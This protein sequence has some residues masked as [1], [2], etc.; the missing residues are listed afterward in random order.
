M[1]TSIDLEDILREIPDE[2]ANM[3]LPDPYLRDLYIDEQDRVIKLDDEITE[4][5]LRI[6]YKIIKYNKEDKGKNIEERKP[7]KILLNT[8]GGSVPVMWSIIKAIKISKT[9]VWTINISAAYSA[10]AHILAAGHKRLAMPGSTVL[11]H[12]GSCVYGGTAEQA[13]NAK[14]YYDAL[15]KEA[16]DLLLQDTNID[17]KTFKKKSPFDWYLTAEEALKQRIID[18]V[19]EDLDAIF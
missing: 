6:I 4:D 16:N 3:Q 17:P 13:D 11:I 8:M 1:S 18:E 10:G 7:I 2:V 9:P 12:S 15:S 5:T 19:I 14:K